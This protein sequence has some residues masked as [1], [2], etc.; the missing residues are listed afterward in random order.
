MPACLVQAA[1]AGLHLLTDESALRSFLQLPPAQPAGPA[2]QQPEVMA[3]QAEGGP[4]QAIPQ[5]TSLSLGLVDEAE[6]SLPTTEGAAVLMELAEVL[7]E[8]LCDHLQ[9]GMHAWM[10]TYSAALFCSNRS[11]IRPILAGAATLM[12]VPWLIAIINEMS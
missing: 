8:V 12:A 7:L 11:A 1:A 5:R 6:T 2:Q 10:L 9:V 4:N 3:A